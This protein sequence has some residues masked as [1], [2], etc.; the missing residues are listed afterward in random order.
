MKITRAK[1]GDGVPEFFR[2]IA[3]VA[4]LLALLFKFL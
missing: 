2:L 3:L 4:M 1:S